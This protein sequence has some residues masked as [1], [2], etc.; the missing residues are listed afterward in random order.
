MFVQ[1]GYVAAI[2]KVLG[3]ANETQKTRLQQGLALS[4][5]QQYVRVHEA[6]QETGDD[7]VHVREQRGQ[8]DAVKKKTETVACSPGPMDQATIVE[9]HHV[10]EEEGDEGDTA[11]VQA[12]WTVTTLLEEAEATVVSADE[13]M[14]Q[15][16]GLDTAARIAAHAVGGFQFEATSSFQFWN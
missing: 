10:R 14:K 6:E 13:M 16:S 3:H 1:F 12:S 5:T 2:C 9:I 7:K 11:S 4:W 15:R 8:N